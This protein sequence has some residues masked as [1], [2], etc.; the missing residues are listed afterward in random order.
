VLDPRHA[1]TTR[2]ERAALAAQAV[3]RRHG[4]P[5]EAAHALKECNNTIV[6]LD[7]L[8]LVA[9]VADTACRP[10]APAALGTELEVA[11][12][13]ARLGVPVVG[14]SRELPVEVHRHGDHAITF[15]RYHH[16]DPD[17]PVDS[18]TAGRLLREVH[19]A[20][21]SYPGPL[22]LFSDRQLRRAG[23][24]LGDPGSLPALHVSDRTF[25]TDQYWALTEELAARPLSLRALHG[26]PHRGNLLACGAGCLVIDFES[27]CIGPLE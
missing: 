12:H 23:Q 27:A 9:K 6:R 22:P 8:P 16:H 26:D 5:V 13:L 17:A 11:G 7:P 25:L 10:S 2:R 15:W 4:L 24:V 19:W 18:W 21:D 3:A 14:P 1:G 20:L